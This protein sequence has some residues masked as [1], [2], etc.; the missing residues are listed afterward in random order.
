MWIH[1]TF[2]FLVEKDTAMRIEIN[3]LMSEEC[4]LKR[5]DYL[6]TSQLGGLWTRVKEGINGYISDMNQTIFWDC[7]KIDIPF[8]KIED[9]SLI[10]ILSESG[11]PTDG[12]DYLF[13]IINDIVSK[14]NDAVRKIALRVNTGEST[15]LHPTLL[16]HQGH[17]NT[18]AFNNF[19][20]YF[21][22]DALI[23]TYWCNN[24][25]NFDSVSLCN[26]LVQDLFLSGKLKTI[27]NPLTCLREKFKFKN[28]FVK[29]KGESQCN[30]IAFQSSSDFIFVHKQDLSVFEETKRSLG[31]EANEKNN[32]TVWQSLK[33][34]FF[35][36]DY[37]DLYTTL[38]GIRT[39]VNTLQEYSNMN[40]K[41]DALYGNIS[42]ETGLGPTHAHQ[43][44]CNLPAD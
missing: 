9:T 13:L 16:I 4:L 8:Q 15:E 39:L 30:D 28:S 31:Y 26:N 22:F 29:E 21:D 43:L 23:E 32:M 44:S 18:F 25:K 34:A 42:F 36:M 7:E 14:Y 10:M 40:N 27:M 37:E 33:I 24:E 38:G 35:T 2:R 19:C 3:D 41:I 5:F 11:H 17:K 6:Q 12:Y 20:G 1:D